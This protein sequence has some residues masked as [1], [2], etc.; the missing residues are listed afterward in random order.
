MDYDRERHF[1]E[2]ECLEKMIT[3]REPIRIGISSKPN[4]ASGLNFGAVFKALDVAINAPQ[5]HVEPLDDMVN[6]ANLFI[7]EYIKEVPD[8]K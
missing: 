2:Q 6:R 7:A 1:Y 8:D 4:Q 5:S 3:M